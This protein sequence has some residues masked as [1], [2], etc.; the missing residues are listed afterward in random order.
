MP[1]TDR[2]REE[3]TG[4]HPVSETV[5]FEQLATLFA[6]DRAHFSVNDLGCGYGALATF[7]QERGY[8]ASYA[9][10]DLSLAML[11]HARRHF[12]DRRHVRF[13]EGMSLVRAD[14]SVASGIFNV[15]LDFGESEW[16][17]YVAETISS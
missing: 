14:Y 3:S 4:T 17:T 13:C 9:G 16:A 1:R 2:Q 11:E 15:K 5:R 6:D 8:A 12:A 10:Y 7:L